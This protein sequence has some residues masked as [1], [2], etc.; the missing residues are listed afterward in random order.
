[1]GILGTGVSLKYEVDEAYIFV[2]I[3]QKTSQH[4]KEIEHN[5]IDKHAWALRLTLVGWTVGLF[6]CPVAA[7]ILLEKRKRILNIQ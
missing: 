2:D 7:T 4:E 1:M 3:D 5:Q 6:A